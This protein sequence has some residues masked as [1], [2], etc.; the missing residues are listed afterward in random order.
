[1]TIIFMTVILVIVIGKLM[2][3]FW[4]REPGDSLAAT[5]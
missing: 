5:I 4:R 3:G 1:M 2:K